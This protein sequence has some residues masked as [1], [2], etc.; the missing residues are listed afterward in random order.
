L[1]EASAASATEG[2]AIQSCNEL[3]VFMGQT[4][5]APRDGKVMERVNNA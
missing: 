2:T 4:L 5:P 1:R 3:L